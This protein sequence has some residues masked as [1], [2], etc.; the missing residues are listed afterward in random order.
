MNPVISNR[1]AK[2]LFL[3]AKKEN[4]LQEISRESQSVIDFFSNQKTA[5]MLLKNPVV[6]KEKKTN[7]FQKSFQGQLSTLMQS[8]IKL[9]IDKG[10]YRDLLSILDQYI[11]IY[12]KEMNIISLELVTT[13]KIN[14]SLKQKI[15]NKLGAQENVVF[16]ETIDPKILGGILIKLNDLQFDATV[17]NKLN[18]VRKTF[19]I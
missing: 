12:K 9:V 14:D 11:E 6:S 10:R 7:I 15:N 1:Y 3:L 18:N 16:K 5:I 13:K 4:V 17:K 19:K 8:F 2:A